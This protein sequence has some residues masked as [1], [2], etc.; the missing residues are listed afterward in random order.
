MGKKNTAATA[1]ATQSTKPESSLKGLNVPDVKIF[2]GIFKAWTR[3]IPDPTDSTKTV[4]RAK[5]VCQV[6]ADGDSEIKVD[7]TAW[8]SE[9]TAK[10]MGIT[11]G[12]KGKPPVAFVGTFAY[13]GMRLEAERG[14]YNEE[15]SLTNSTLIAVG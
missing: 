10:N 11:I 13:T 8:I 9:D 4:K 2:K 1:A 7:V 15:R 12:D 3:T 6:P 5:C 14:Q